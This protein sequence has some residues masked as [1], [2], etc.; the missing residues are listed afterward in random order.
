[1]A[2]TMVPVVVMA[3]MM[4]AAATAKEPAPTGEGGIGCQHHR[5]S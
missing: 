2:V 4:S 1:M 5:D 3:L